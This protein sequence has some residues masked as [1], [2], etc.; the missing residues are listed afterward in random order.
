MPKKEPQKKQIRDKSKNNHTELL[1]NLRLQN[2]QL[3]AV[4]Q[5]KDE[6]IAL[7][8]H[9]LRTPATGVKQYL[10]LLLEGYTE[11]LTDDQRTFIERAYE[12]NERQLQIV[13]EILRVTQVDLNKI[14]L[15]P[16]RVNVVA[17]LEEEIASLRGKFEAKKQT[18]KFLKPKSPIIITTDITQMRSVIDNLLENASNYSP[19][20]TTI[21]VQAK[22][23]KKVSISIEDEG[24]GISTQDMSKLFQKFSRLDNPLSTHVNGTG[25]G[26][27]ISKRIIELQGGTIK[28]NSKPNE[29]SR[30]T[31]EV[32]A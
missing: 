20:K 5:S 11:P 1:D 30:F 2:E 16:T 8:S 7:A 18:V 4:N 14:I 28:V 31:I 15:H 29:G 10:S 12:N 17:I 25:L 9:Q 6:F 21:T 24:V 32:P 26:L 22:K 27:Y 13:D 3:M 19:S 23:N